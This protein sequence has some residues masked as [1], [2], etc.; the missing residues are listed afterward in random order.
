MSEQGTPSPAE[1]SGGEAKR[2]K[3]IRKSAAEAKVAEP[4]LP[5]IG[6]PPAEISSEL[7]EG[8][9]SV[10]AT[11]QEIAE[12]LGVNVSTL[13]RRFAE[14]LSKTRS[15]M[16][17]KLRRVQMQS[18]LSGNVAMMIWLGKQILDQKERAEISVDDGFAEGMPMRTF[19]DIA[20]QPIPGRP[21]RPQLPTSS[22]PEESEKKEA[23]RLP[24]IDVKTTT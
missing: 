24:V 1:P 5:K 21:Q 8:M 6:R 20:D 4:V 15:G 14:K 17:V 18:A 12:F 7:V 11:N 10:G 22:R 19:L 9:A 23:E 16:R 3:R 13:T 2:P